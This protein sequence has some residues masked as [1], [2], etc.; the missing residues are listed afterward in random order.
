M[1]LISA[2]TLKTISIVKKPDQ[3]FHNFFTVNLLVMK[4]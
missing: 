2:E 1:M 4:K 3:T